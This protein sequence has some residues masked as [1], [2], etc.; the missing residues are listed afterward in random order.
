MDDRRVAPAGEVER[1]FGTPVGGPGVPIVEPVGH[2]VVASATAGIWRVRV[3]ERSAVLK[4]LAHAPGGTGNWRS[5]ASEDH[6]YYWRREAEAY[7]SGLLASLAGG[8][9]A[10]TCHLV[11][12]RDDG[13]VALWLEDLRGAPATA[14]PIERYGAAARH[15]GRAQGEFACGRPPPTDRWLSRGWLRAYLTQRDGDLALLDDPTAWRHPLVAAAFPDPPVEE[16]RAMRGGQDRFL[17]ALDAMPRTLAH[18]DL[19]PANLFDADG[20][21][22]VVDWAFVGIGAL[23]EDPGNLVPDAALDFHVPPHQ[24]DR[25]HATV[26]DG[27]AAG[28]R[29]AGWDGSTEQ[30][31]L[32]MAA[33]MA[34]KYAWI[35]PAILRATSEGRPLLNR[36][37]VAEALAA[38]APTVHFLLARAREAADLVGRLT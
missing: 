25:L 11:A 2:T 19:H 28:L 14:W 15:L 4:V 33:T 17:A 37:P 26:L 31:R 29:D 5:G 24:L 22:A 35:G 30:V 3:G 16:L 23:G 8:L 9:R 13:S 6:W 36:R 27:Y 1:V 32:S 18:L 20:G 38:W 10:P 34:A 21:T 12:E 7:G